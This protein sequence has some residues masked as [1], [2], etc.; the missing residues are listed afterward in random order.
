MG[1]GLMQLV[2][3]GAQ[4][5]YLTGNP[6][7]TFFKVVYR[8][9]TNFS[10]ETIQQTLSGSS[11]TPLG[12]SA[13][14]TCV[15]SRNGDLVYRVYARVKSSNDIII[16]HPHYSSGILNFFDSV[17]LEIGGQLIDRHTAQWMSVWE[18]ISQTNDNFK[19]IWGDGRGDGVYNVFGDGGNVTDAGL[20][21]YTMNPYRYINVPF[22][23]WFCRNPGLALPLIALQ[24]HEVKIKISTIADS[25]LFSNLNDVPE[26]TPGSIDYDIF[27]DYIYLDTDERRRFAQVS[28]E[29]LIEQVQIQGGGSNSSQKLNFNHPVKFISWT[30]QNGTQSINSDATIQLNGHDRFSKQSPEYFYKKQFIDYFNPIEQ[31]MK[32]HTIHSVAGENDNPT[33]E[34]N[35]YRIRN[36]SIVGNSAVGGSGSNTITYT[37]YRL[38]NKTDNIKKLIRIEFN[39]HWLHINP[40]E[41]GN[42]PLQ[43]TTK[44]FGIRLWISDSAD[45]GNNYIPPTNGYVSRS[46]SY[47][48][49]TS[50][51]TTDFN[52]N[53]AK[54]NNDPSTT[55]ISPDM[56]EVNNLILAAANP[57]DFD[58]VGDGGV[59]VSND[60]KIQAGHHDNSSDYPLSHFTFTPQTPPSLT[61]KYLFITFYAVNAFLGGTGA[62]IHPK[63]IVIKTQHTVQPT[64][65]EIKLNVGNSKI[66]SSTG[67]HYFLNAYSFA[68]K[69]LEHQPS[70]TCNFSRIDN[71]KLIFEGGS[72]P[73]IDNI[74]A[75]NY[76]V[77][78]IMSGM[79][80][81]AYSN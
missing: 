12:G 36:H 21:N 47:K 2:A 56:Q 7:I 77:L 43:G 37:T 3:Y 41:L 14:S 26:D 29:Y 78:R 15:I 52:E 40:L 64:L 17:E 58:I 45:I 33:E 74:Y 57:A 60:F 76:N 80:G 59:N 73:T 11:S 13:S 8:R 63:N 48:Y 75:V 62:K 22:N 79:G 4:D 24:Y 51:P 1:G 61:G 6:Q 9:H 25:Y 34:D 16:E 31:M 70:G 50:A 72:S 68:L 19:V 18:N 20:I 71:A 67:P 35:P 53:D 69:P 46:G 42:D 81:L 44:K 27:C 65:D 30:T 54:P 66:V 23:F 28:H 39:K 55:P 10:M 5:I 49:G 38:L 32:Q